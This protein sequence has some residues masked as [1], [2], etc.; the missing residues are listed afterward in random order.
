MTCERTV[1]M[2]GGERVMKFRCG[3]C[4]NGA[5]IEKSPGCMRGVLEALT[6]NPDVDMVVLSGIYEH[7]YSGAGLRALK[8]IAEILRENRRWS[9][10]H[11]TP[12]DCRR[13]EAPRRAQLERALDELSSDP[14]SGLRKLQEISHE[15]LSRVRRGADRCKACRSEFVGST[16]GPMISSLERSALLKSGDDRAK[17][18]QPLA[19]PCFLSS[20]LQM[21]PPPGCELVDTYGVEGSE[22]KIYRLSGQLQNLYFLVPPEY[23]LPHDHVEL[24][25]RA[26]QMMIEQVPSL[27]PNPLRAREQVARVGENLMAK[28]VVEGRL[29]ISREDVRCLAAHLARFTA[30]LG[31]LEALLADPKVQDIYVDAPVGRTPVHITHRDHDEC[32]TNIFLTPDDAESLISRFRAISGRPFSEADPVLDL[33]LG[34][35]RVAAIGRPL[36][37]DGLAFALRR[38]KPTPW[39]LPQFIQAKF[40]TPFAAGLLGLLVDAQTSLLVTG[41][42]GAGKTSLLGALM[43]ELLPKFRIITIEDTR[44]LQVEQLRRLGFKIQALQVQSVVSGA[45][46]ELRA[47]DALRAALRLGES[48]LVIGEVRSSIRGNEEVVVVESGWMKRV[49]IA[50]LVNKPIDKILIPTLDENY[51]IRLTKLSGFIKH[52]PRKKLLKVTTRTGRTVTVTHDHSLFTIDGFKITPV[53]TS[54]MRPGDRVILPGFMPCGYNDLEYLDVTEIVSESRLDGVDNLVRKAISVLGWKRATKICKIRC[55]DIY[56]YFRTNQKT[57]IPIK[58]F[59]A[60]MNEAGIRYS[61]D[62]IKVKHVNSTPVPARIPVNKK[63]CRFLGY[64]VSKGFSANGGVI[65][66]NSNKKILKDIV[67]ISRDLFGIDPVIRETRGFGRSKHVL[68]Q[69]SPLARLVSRLGCGRTCTEKRVPPLIF[70]LSKQKIGEFLKALYSGDGSFYASKRSGNEVRYSS[71]S[72][73]LAEDVMYLLLTHKIVARICKRKGKKRRSDIWRVEFKQRD[74]VKTFLNEIGFVQKRPRMISQALSH[75]TA[76]VVIFSKEELRRH[77]RLRRRYRHLSRYCRCSKN[78]LQRVVADRDNEISTQLHKF[79]VGEFYL[80]E[81]KEIKEVELRKPEPVYDLSVNPSENFVGGF[82]G[83]LLHNTEVRTLYEAMRVGA[84]GNS[85]MGTIHGATARDVFERVVYDLGVTPNSFKATDAIVVATPIRLRGSA[86]R[87]RRLVQITEVKKGWRRDPVAEEGFENL[88]YY[89]RTDDEI[90]PTRALQEQRSELIAGIARKWGTAPREVMR[91]LEMR[92]KIHEVLVET[93]ARLKK[94]G[95]LE[96]DFVVRSNLA[97][98]ALFEEQLRHGRVNY[99]GVLRGWRAWLQNAAGEA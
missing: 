13:C 30:G 90:R 61:L 74:A 35:V 77:S 95:L 14:A 89:N 49:P 53:E 5:S 24:L 97:W 28:L 22:V 18:L 7:E 37:P 64:Y 59:K 70:G 68:I 80:D 99:V 42:R 78:Y 38:H 96:A 86:A 66:T 72:K 3:S 94:P 93:A 19:R 56:N 25:Q 67:Y 87:V 34:G 81:I 71:T 84:A 91:N 21:E 54:K 79:A 40:M 50:S 8:E 4:Q 48:V 76:N 33:N 10:A 36:S 82:G 29:Q 27:D 32:I 63:F 58:A 73:K 17:I 98:H 51:K 41:T 11:L 52:P 46:A 39:T 85:V 44:E 26:R 62:N 92:A 47:E 12:E 6:E 57:R 43:F 69:S 16:L 20:R 2:L 88:M 75:S 45:D 83:I 23:H 65:I 55:G 15:M 9:L 31:L 1:V 60:L